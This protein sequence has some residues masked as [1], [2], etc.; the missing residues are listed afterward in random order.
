MK[1]FTS[2]LAMLLIFAT[3]IIA[4]TT[5]YPFTLTQEGEEPV[6]YFIYS[7]RDGNG[8]IGDYVFS[9]TRAYNA[10]ND[11]LGL[12][13]KD[14]RNFLEQLWYFM[15]AE[16]G[17]IM[18]ISAYDNS[19]VSVA[20]TTDSPKCAKLWSKADAENKYYTWILDNTNGCYAFKTSNGK[21]FLSHNGNWSTG[22]QY[23]GLYKDNGSKDEG[24]R[25]FF[26]A[27]PLGIVT[28]ITAPTT[29]KNQETIK[30]IYTLTGQK[31][32]NITKAGIYIIDGKKIF[33]K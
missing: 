22:G 31:I 26:E 11:G 33:V 25:V 15:E 13:R 32:E 10:K 4:Q 19:L 29:V 5:N 23:M 17:C 7:G 8:G 2:L 14:P 21:T 12:S 1:K 27:A 16:D 6:L 30:G 9:N 18:I 20:N 24:S 28:G 3:T